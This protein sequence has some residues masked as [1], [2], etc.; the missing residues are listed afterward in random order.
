MERMI[1]QTLAMNFTSWCNFEYFLPLGFLQQSAHRLGM[2]ITPDG[3]DR[4]IMSWRIEELLRDLEGDEYQPV[5][6]YLHGENV[7]L[8]RYQLA[9]QLANVFDQYQM[10]RPE[11]LTAWDDNRLITGE[12][13]ELWQK[14][15]WVR[16]V[17]QLDGVPHR[18]VVL[19]KVITELGSG[20]D[21]SRV[22]PRRVSVF[23]LSIMPPIFLRYLQM[24]AAHSDVH[25][26][27]L[28]P[29][30]EYW[31][32]IER[33][34][35][36][37]RPTIE[38]KAAMGEEMGDILENHPLLVALGQQGRDFQRMLF[39]DDV[40]FELEFSSYEDPLT[41]GRKCLLRQLQ[42]DLLDGK[43]TR[44]QDQWDKEDYSIRIISSH[45]RLR[46]ITILKE[47]ILHYLYQDPGLQLRDIVVM[48]PD[49]QEYAS[50][51]PAVFDT[52]QHSISDR[53][54]RRR[55]PVL[56]AFADFI[57]LFNGRFGWDEVLELLKEPVISEKLQLVQVD[58]ENLQRWVVEAGV[59]WGLSGK[60]R[61]E[62]GLPEFSEGSWKHGIERLLMGYAIASE[63]FVDGVLPFTD[64]EG[65]N[66]LALGG[67][68]Q[69]LNLIEHAQNVFC[70]SLTLRDWSKHLTQIAGDLFGSEA[71]SGNTREYH[72][73]YEILL[74]L[75][76][77]SGEL[78]QSEV[79]FTVISSWLEHTSKETRSS[80][81]FLRGQLTFCSMLPMRSI[82]FKVVCLIGLND[83]TFPKNDNFAT[84]DL[85]GS[86]HRPGDR[87]RRMD[88]RYQ[89]L[90]VLMAA[91]EQL[92]ISYIGQSIKNNDKLPPSVVVSELL[93]VLE[94]CYGVTEMVV[95]HPLHPFSR[96]Y[97]NQETG[98]L[99]SYDEKYCKVAQKLQS[100]HNAE[101]PWWS[102]QREM[103]ITEISLS[104]LFRFY[105]NPQRWYVRDCLGISVAG[106]VELTAES[107]MFSHSGLDNFLINN[108]LLD[109]ILAG[110]EAENRV[111]KM[112]AT[113]RW[114]LGTPGDI[115]FEKKITELHD[116][117]NSISA[118]NMGL[119]QEPLEIDLE[120]DGYR[121]VGKL[122][123]IYEN[124]S[125]IW[126]YTKM[127]GKDLLR[128]WLHYLLYERMTGKAVDVLMLNSDRRC[129][130]SEGC[131]NIPDL[132]TLVRLFICGNRQPSQ[133]YIEPGISWVKKA[134][135]NVGMMDAAYATLANNLETGY[136]PETAL[137]LQGCDLTSVLGEEFVSLCETVLQPIWR[138]ANGQ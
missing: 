91:R 78:H 116:F 13:A 58:L 36:L 12:P 56:A 125:L 18:G 123:D 5:K 62:M 70:K 22:L 99:F 100:S 90:E 114:P 35:S 110:S 25:L 121:L 83:G 30:R 63:E 101:R 98:N 14:S 102:G 47:H 28:S 52:I 138:N 134:E 10:M 137:L 65:G 119:V 111:K 38:S 85:M 73:L 34:R 7:E 124:G 71:S 93:E 45:S 136:E 126:R 108:E 131:E 54:L 16:L 82:P 32:D 68:C 9:E 17:S 50:L 2:D 69:F 79:D 43:M 23:G 19:Q 112:Q 103:T 76:E 64:V 39:A 66:A 105:A 95:H 21:Y 130:F 74:G 6:R 128:G 15:L 8:K 80:S 106:E 122:S 94:D 60:Q 46:E 72:E 24:L 55:N 27:V 40:H 26:Y 44:L 117:A 49:I 53:S 92:Y 20:K 107:E 87:S 11:M 96:K 120:V 3:Y 89:F 127:G 135:K 57:A 37:M 86:S 4:K 84:F 97:F 77:Q 104:D 81:G 61:L 129:K 133:L 59:R 48:A 109:C 113:G 118:F 75:G 41:S 51:I 88:D 1:S 33:R 29:C 132:E 115:F 42:S 67:L 31:G